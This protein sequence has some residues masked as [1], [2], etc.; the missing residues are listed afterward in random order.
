M[1]GMLKKEQLENIGEL[2]QRKKLL[3]KLRR[4]VA[5]LG[6]L[7]RLPSRKLMQECSRMCMMLC[8][9]GSS[10]NHTGSLSILLLHLFGHPGLWCHLMG[11]DLEGCVDR[12]MSIGFRYVM[13]DSTTATTMVQGPDPPQKFHFPG[14][15]YSM[16]KARGKHLFALLSHW[17]MLV[18]GQK[19]KSCFGCRI[20]CAEMLQSRPL[21]SSLQM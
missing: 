8:R 12:W 21:S 11:Q 9:S 6:W 18:V 7:R 17:R 16:G 15:P 5:L 19:T 1:P 14:N 4:N 2:R 20:L 3:Y 13:E 10:V